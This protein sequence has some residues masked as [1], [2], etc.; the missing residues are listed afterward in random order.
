MANAGQQRSSPPDISP[1]D[2]ASYA[3]YTRNYIYDRAEYD[4]NPSFSTEDRQ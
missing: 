2:K 3:N 4:T 1:F